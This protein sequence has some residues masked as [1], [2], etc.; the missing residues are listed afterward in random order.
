MPSDDAQGHVHAVDSERGT[1]DFWYYLWVI[2]KRLWLLVAVFV[3]GMTGTLLYVST[4]RPVYKA[5]AQLLVT[6]AKPGSVADD[7][8][9][10][11]SYFQTEVVVETQKE[12][13]KNL[14]I[15]EEVVTALGLDKQDSGRQ[16]QDPSL[17]QRFH[18]AV[19]RLIWSTKREKDGPEQPLVT[20]MAQSILANLDVE[21]V[22][23]SLSIN[24][25]YRDANP[26]RAALILNAIIRAHMDQEKKRRF[27]VS[28]E[29]LE[30]LQEQAEVR[31][32]ALKKAE[33]D[34][35]EYQ[36][37]MKEVSLEERR[38][39]TQDKLTDLNKALHDA[40][41]ARMHA[42]ATRASLQ[43]HTKA[44]KALDTFPRANPLQSD[45]FA[46]VKA[47]L[48]DLRSQ[49]ISLNQKYGPKHPQMLQVRE[50]I[51]AIEAQLA[52]IGRNIVQR[53]EAEY[54]LAVTREADFQRALEEHKKQ[55]FELNDRA[56]EYNSRKLEVESNRRLLE[57]I[58][59]EISQTGLASTIKE[60][61]I[62]VVAEARIPTMPSGPMRFYSLAVGTILSLVTGCVLA[63]ALEYVD[64]SVKTGDEIERHVK[65]PFLGL[66]DKYEGDGSAGSAGS[67]YL[68]TINAPKSNTS[69]NFRKIRTNIIFSSQEANRRVLLVTSAVPREGKTLVSVNLAVVMAQS[70]KRVLLV[71]CDLRRPMI[72]KVMNCENVKGISNFLAGLCPLDDIIQ[73]TQI[74]NLWLVTSGPLP[75]NQSELLGSEPMRTF[76]SEVGKRFDLVIVDCA[77][78]TSVADALVL[79]SMVD[80]VVE[81]VKSHSTARGLLEQATQHL[82]DV[83][84]KVI[85]VILNYVDFQKTGYAYGK[86]YSYRY[87]GY[88]DYSYYS[89]EDEPKLQQG[90]RPSKSHRRSAPNADATEGDKT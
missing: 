53:V 23:G 74:E 6:T 8:Y 41:T 19:R 72:H 36:K 25:S 68:V 67:A 82:R 20:Q 38:N 42:E 65:A 43:E 69:E 73:S 35:N 58:L 10:G 4:L 70:G 66:I 49:E 61:S 75:P 5:T 64:N 24:V 21:R 54:Q 13:L 33:Q 62:Q 26:E 3:V 50:Q 32:V 29:K 1:T 9:T 87:Y 86:Y 46:K 55:I 31:R 78:V 39:I 45:D 2:Q 34:L 18:K 59:Q 81:V 84:A 88:Y 79:G 40:Q 7:D 56:I 60:S 37:Q 11:A 27:R 57:Q 30:W 16:E 44:G 51:K 71:D 48:I 83:N 47:T 12:L 52:E 80:G 22:R 89:S 17:F 28:T 76:L 90:K 63:F 85:G 15:A 14:E 77:P